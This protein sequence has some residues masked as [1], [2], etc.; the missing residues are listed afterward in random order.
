VKATAV[1]GPPAARR[2]TWWLFVA[3]E[4]LAVVAVPVVALVGARA[5]LDTRAGTFVTGPRPEDPGFQ[6]L[7]EPTPVQAVVERR[8]GELTGITLL[9]RPGVDVEG[10]AVV[11]VPAELEVDGR[12]LA[13]WAETSDADAVDALARAL[14]LGL[15][16]PAVVDE[17]GWADLLGERAVSVTSPDPVLVDGRRRFAS[18]ELEL[19]AEDAADWLG[20]LGNQQPSALLFRRQLWWE[21]LLGA[22][23]DESGQSEPA[24]TIAH[25]AAGPHAVELLPVDVGGGA[26]TS[27]AEAAEALIVEVVPFPAGAQPGDRP[28]VRVLDRTGEA[29]LDAVARSVARAGGEVVVVGNAGAFDDQ[30]TEA[31]IADPAVDEAARR[32]VDRIGTGTVTLSPSGDDTVDVTVLA[33]PDLVGQPG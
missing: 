7:V 29:E 9:A 28:R 30:P 21:A 16:E 12:T 33:G 22:G 27:D 15:G 18:G 11:L 26:V 6:A 24:A 13:E 3:L 4:V 32:L 14:R 31:V 17:D 23:L 1:P 2:W 8:D 20:L 5:L 19:G 10:G 25:L